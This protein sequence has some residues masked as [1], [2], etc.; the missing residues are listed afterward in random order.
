MKWTYEFWEKKIEEN[1]EKY[2]WISEEPQP[3]REP[4]PELINQRGIYKDSHKASQFWADYQL[5]C[6]FP[7]AVAVVSHNLSVFQGDDYFLTIRH[8][9]YL[10]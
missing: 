1:F 4:K 2:F 8:I 5:R 6:N 9:S 10:K 7:I 3:E